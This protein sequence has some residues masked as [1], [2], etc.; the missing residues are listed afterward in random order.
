MITCPSIFCIYGEALPFFWCLEV[1]R[2]PQKGLIIDLIQH[3][4]HILSCDLWW[5]DILLGSSLTRRKIGY[6]LLMSKRIS[7]YNYCFHQ[8]S[9][10]PLLHIFFPGW[11]LLSHL[12]VFFFPL[13][14]TLGWPF[15]KL[16]VSFPM[17]SSA[18]STNGQMSWT[19]TGHGMGA[20]GNKWI[21]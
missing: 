11:T 15:F 6:R 5:S 7:H 18:S 16:L 13:F 21:M 20:A 3:S 10:A 4:L 9:L 17:G 1:Q 8:L 19:I 12:L 14:I 2:S